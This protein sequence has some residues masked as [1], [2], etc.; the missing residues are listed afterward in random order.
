MATKRGKDKQIVVHS[1][2]G[3]LLTNEKEQATGKANTWMTVTDI[4]LRKEA[5]P[6]KHIPYD[7]IYVMLVYR[8]S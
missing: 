1:Y 7:S 5:R 3:I 2:S 8:L 4:K 6:P